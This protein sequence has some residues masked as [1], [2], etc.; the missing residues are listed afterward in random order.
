MTTP[1]RATPPSA[2]VETMRHWPGPHPGRVH[3]KGSPARGRL[4][5]GGGG[6]REPGDRRPGATIRFANGNGNPGVHDGAPA[7]RSM[8][9]KLSL[10]DGK[11][12]DIL[13]NSVDGFVARTPEE[14][15][16]FLRAQLPD[17]TTGRPDP[18]ALPRFLGAHPAALAFVERVGKR[19]VPASYAQVTYHA[20]HAFRFTPAHGPSRFGRYRFAPLAG[21]AF[22]APD[23]AGKRDPSFL[24]AE[25]ESRLRAGPARFRL[26][27]QM[28]AG[29]D[30]TDDVTA[31]WRDEL[32][33]SG[34]E[35]RP[36]R[37][38]GRRAAPDLRSDE[39]RDGSTVRRPIARS[40]AYS[41][42]YEGA[43]GRLV[44]AARLAAMSRWPSGRRRA[45]ARL[46]ARHGACSAGSDNAVDEGRLV[47]SK[48]TPIS[49]TPS[50]T[51]WPSAPSRR[52]P[53]SRGGKHS[54]TITAYAGTMPPWKSPNSA[55]TT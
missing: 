27:L 37:R 54:R 43:A 39:P 38:R 18:D 17:P 25:L 41:I 31:L 10:P 53:A 33:R 5:V 36:R 46:A 29:G 13:A 11:S 40:A 26:L 8:A 23:D 51:R 15:L 44:L 21:E 47:E 32:V 55:E 7:V 45:P 1:P 22:L 9:V 2:I 49:A 50:R 19:A 28:A 12:A 35:T 34:A 48:S 16:E 4:R 14:L 6:P 52:T 20:E 24:R 42:S 3:A 30:P